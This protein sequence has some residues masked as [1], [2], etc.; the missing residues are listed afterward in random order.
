MVIRID[1]SKRYIKY[2]TL[3]ELSVH[4][5]HRHCSILKLPP[6]NRTCAVI[7]NKLPLFLKE[8]E[9][10]TQFLILTELFTKQR[11]TCC[12]YITSV[13]LI[14]YSVLSFF[15]LPYTFIESPQQDKC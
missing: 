8:K 13:S 15:K 14:C 4:M 12:L 10:T 2:I 11:K 5:H 6:P 7:L 3:L 9:K 1:D